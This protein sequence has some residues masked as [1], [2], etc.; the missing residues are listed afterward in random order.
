MKSANP[1][2]AGPDESTAGKNHPQH[3]RGKKF[4]SDQTSTIE[5]KMQTRTADQLRAEQALRKL[6][7]N[8]RRKF[9][10][11]AKSAG[12]DPLVHMER[13]LSHP[14]ARAGL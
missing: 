14:T 6:S 7:P 5:L 9:D 3:N 2:R 1:I 10:A 4:M 13:T 11:A 8:A 12:L